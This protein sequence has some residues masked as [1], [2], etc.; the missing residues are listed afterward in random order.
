MHTD[1]VSYHF[2]NQRRRR[3]GDRTLALNLQ[4]EQV[5]NDFELGACLLA[6]ESGELI[7]AS[8]T[9]TTAYDKALGALKASANGAQDGISVREFHA[10]GS[11]YLVAT[12]GQE[13]VM[14]EV[15]V[16]RAILGV[17]RIHTNTR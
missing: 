13:P 9:C 1:S 5:V 7:A 12:S 6:D 11:R 14:N 8:H 15:G 2:E 17:R 16:Y 10:S 3:S 4:L